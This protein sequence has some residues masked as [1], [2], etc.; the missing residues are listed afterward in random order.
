MSKGLIATLAGVVAIAVIAAGCGSSS[1]DSTSSLT[2]AEFIKQGDAICEKGNK[3]DEAEFEAFAK[4]NNISQSK[5]PSK[6]QEEEL[7]KTVILPSISTQAE[8]LGE[9]GAPSGEE[10]QVNAIVEGVEEAV[11]KAEEDPSTVLKGNGPFEEVDT[12][13]KE[14]G[15]KVC[16]Q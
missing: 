4:E 2:K 9:L 1:S 5:E 6:A 14:Y 13:T 8:E 3:N 16:G 15:L 12:L 7:V 10:D 11:E